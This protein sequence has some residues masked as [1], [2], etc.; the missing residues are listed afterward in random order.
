MQTGTLP[1]TLTTYPN[2]MRVLCEPRL[3]RTFTRRSGYGTKT[4]RTYYATTESGKLLGRCTTGK[5]KT[6]AH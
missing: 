5:G 6:R 2:G 4:V 3:V 1:T